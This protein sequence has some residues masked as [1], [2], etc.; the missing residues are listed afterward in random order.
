[1][2]TIHLLIGIPGCGKSTFAN[3][4]NKELNIEIV[5]TDAVRM[6]NPG[7][8]EEEVWPRVYSRIGELLNSNLDV[9]FDATNITPKVRKR[10]VDNVIVHCEKFDI[11]AYYFNV[12]WHICYDRVNKRNNDPNEH[13][14]PVEVVEGYGQ[15]IIEPSFEEGFIEIKYIDEIGN[16]YQIKYKEGGNYESRL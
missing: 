3:K 9:I 10:L 1:M 5:S 7:I 6:N 4:M 11:V 8:L 14:L 16:I 13:Y 15:K 2:A 12:D